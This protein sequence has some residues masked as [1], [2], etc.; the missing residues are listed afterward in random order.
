M[1]RCLVILGGYM[2]VHWVIVWDCPETF[3]PDQ[4]VGCL[5]GVNK[6]GMIFPPLAEKCRWRL[7][8]GHGF[9]NCSTAAV[10][11]CAWSDISA[12]G[13]VITS[14]VRSRTCIVWS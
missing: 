1:C 5:S 14:D 6:A 2:A 7:W 12:L 10:V 13:D 4:Q 9:P 11:A 8:P 3:P